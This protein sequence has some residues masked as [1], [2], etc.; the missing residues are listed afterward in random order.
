MNKTIKTKCCN[1]EMTVGFCTSNG[2]NIESWTC[3]ECGNF[4]VITKGQLDV[5]E[6]DNMRNI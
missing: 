4:V 3:L 6:L 1:K 5:E 2:T